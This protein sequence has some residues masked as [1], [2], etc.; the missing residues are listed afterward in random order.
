MKPAILLSILGLA[1]A[2]PSS[3]GLNRRKDDGDDTKTMKLLI[4]APN[5]VLVA[6]Y[7]GK[8]FD[9]KD[10][11]NLEGRPSWML[12]KGSTNTIYSVDEDSDKLL[13]FEFEPGYELADGLNEES[14]STGV[15]HLAFNKNQT[16]MLGSSYGE[17]TLDVWNI[18][19]KNPELI[20]TL[21]T[22]NNSWPFPREGQSRLHQAVL[23]PTG[24]FFAVNDLETDTILVVDARDD[25]KYNITNYHRVEDGCGPRHGVF[26]GEDADKKATHYTVVCEKSNLLLTY[27]VGYKETTLEFVYSQT[28]STF[29]PANP[30]KNVTDAAA[31]ALIYSKPNLYVSNRLTGHEEDDFSHFTVSDKGQLAFKKGHTSKADNPRMMSFSLD[32]SHLFVANIEGPK[33]L[34]AFKKGDDGNL[35]DASHADLT[36]WVDDKVE[37]NNGP[38]FVMEVD[39]D[40][41]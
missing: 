26:H 6:D 9:V 27:K 18:S 19:N 4:G 3:S 8:K 10:R 28:M 41:K 40:S 23:E 36:R 30:P 24:K 33:S 34:H 29:D 35:E 5:R 25:D 2:V 11:L 17:G 31:G 22:D 14:G 15:V 12:Y 39:T 32:D 20:D 38:W 21:N 37:E 7:D 1:A 13:Y 16:R